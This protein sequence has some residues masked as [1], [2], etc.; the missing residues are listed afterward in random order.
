M[1]NRFMCSC[2]ELLLSSFLILIITGC[3][4]SKRATSIPKV[5]NMK[6]LQA[7]KMT[8]GKSN[9]V[10]SLEE[11]CKQYFAD[12]PISIM[13]K[14]QT[15]GPNNH[16]FCSTG[17][18]WWPD[19]EHPGK[20]I[21]RDGEVNP[22][23]KQYDRDRLIEMTKR[24]KNLSH[25][26]YLTGDNTYYDAF[27]HQL[28]VWFIDEDTYM[29]PNFEYAQVIPGQRDNK[30]RSTGMIDAYYFNTIIESIRLVNSVKKIDRLTMKALQSWFF[31]FAQWADN[32]Y[33]TFF[34]KVDNNISLAFDVTTVNMYLFAGNEKR[35]KEIVDDF[36]V[37]RID[38]QIIEDGSQPVELKRTRAFSYSMFNLTHIVDMCYLARYW[39]SNYYHEHHKRIDKA[40]EFLG[41]YVEEPEK[42]P[43]QQITSWDKCVNNYRYQL[44]RIKALD[45]SDD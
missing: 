3:N 13:D 27:V 44:E 34:K 37:L 38:R 10:K 19:A 9:Y 31:E 6:E 8:V 28:N 22:E 17:P 11:S 5:W 25:A 33:G 15:F 29:L 35:A 2:R 41:Q 21:N 4:T 20:Y 16:Y 18:Y 30:G 45:K 7:A 39:Y 36:A 43:Y 24:C 14:S 1:I 42:F 26:F 23:S 12:E 40:F 32:S